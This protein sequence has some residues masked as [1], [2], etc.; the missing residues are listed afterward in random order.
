M[1]LNRLKISDK[2][3]PA[4]RGRWW[5]PVLCVL[6][7]GAGFGAS[8]LVGRIRLPSAVGVKT[9]AVLPARSGAGKEVV[10]GGWIEVPTPAY[11]IVV[12]ARVSE[13]IENLLVREGQM[14]RPGEVIARLYR[15]DIASR[16]ALARARQEAAR[17]RLS[18]Q[19]AGF[20]RED[21]AAA[22]AREAGARER[23]RITKADYLRSKALPKGAISVEDLDR[24]HS[25]FK[26]AGASHARTLAE[27][28]KM[29]AGAR[30]EDIAV[31]RAEL[32]EAGS[33]V[34]L[35]EREL[36]YCTIRAPKTGPPLRVLKVLHPPGDWIDVRRHP[37]LVLLYDPKDMQARVDA[38]QPDIR[39][40][41]VGASATITTEADPA[42]R[43]K[44]T[45][46]RIDPLAE[47]AKNTVTVRVRIQNPDA[48]LFPEMVAHVTF[49][50][51]GAASRPS[52]G[53][54]APQAAV[55]SEGGRHF[56][57]VY[58]DGKA[59]RRKITV[60]GS[61]GSQAIVAEGLR[62]GQRVI[63]GDLNRL[64]DGQKVQE[65]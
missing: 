13:R 21:I 63:V 9:V 53:V 18:R 52:A 48:M 4:R 59:M 27:L 6:C 25:A 30:V 7:L 38:M 33:R 37:E 60:S 42:R 65:R 50:A 29:N 36:S 1:D 47:L 8:V 3:S 56:V 46:L 28:A 44:G 32:A 35:I 49:H 57:F 26:L 14:L 15:K 34:E 55:L 11:P 64:Q 22:A 16:L 20:R 10:A 41:A 62:S 2:D 58:E 54:L 51:A 12:S 17:Q 5:I 61:Q 43:Y 24:Q 19:K 23:L 39:S 45:V 40:I 31:A